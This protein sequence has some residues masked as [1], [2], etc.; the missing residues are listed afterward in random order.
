VVRKSELPFLVGMQSHE[1][2]WLTTLS[3]L[4]RGAGTRQTRRVAGQAH[5]EVPASTSRQTRP[6]AQH[7]RGVARLATWRVLEIP[8]RRLPAHLQDRRRPLDRSCPSRRPAQG[9]L[10]L[11]NSLKRPSQSVFRNREGIFP[12]PRTGQHELFSS[13]RAARRRCH[14]L[15]TR[16][17]S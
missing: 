8:C 5:P 9:N 4:S 15:A 16:E 6:S 3:C 13:D 17:G 2:A 7:R 11:I 14:L 10:S 1:A 12:K